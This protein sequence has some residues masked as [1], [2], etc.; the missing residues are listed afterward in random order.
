MRVEALTSFGLGGGRIASPG[1]VIDV[2][3]A[4]AR[5]LIHGRMA[6]AAPEP[7][8][9]ASEPTPAVPDRAPEKHE[10]TSSRRSRRRR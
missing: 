9:A 5:E 4:H 2:P 3:P 1:D 6:I 7:E 10:P 8:E